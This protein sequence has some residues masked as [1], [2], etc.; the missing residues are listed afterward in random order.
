MCTSADK[1]RS[2][3]VELINESGSSVV[4]KPRIT[5]EFL[6][7]ILAAYVIRECYM[8]SRVSSSVVHSQS[9]T[10]M[11]MLAVF[12]VAVVIGVHLFFL[13]GLLFRPERAAKIVFIWLAVFT[14][15]PFF[16]LSYRIEHSLVTFADPGFTIRWTL[17]LLT[18]IGVATI[19]YVHYRWHVGRA[20]P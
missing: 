17:S 11:V 1:S 16:W 8:F 5:L 3:W 7:G 18:R 12:F 10:S 9:H 4:V 19:A 14:L 20:D 13:F 15:V 2:D 6:R